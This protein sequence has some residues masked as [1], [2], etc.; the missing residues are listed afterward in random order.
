MPDK[1]HDWEFGIR[2]EG[3]VGDSTE[4]SVVL[5]ENGFNYE[6]SGENWGELPEGWVYKEA[7]A[8][9]VDSKDRVY[10]FNRGT[11]PVIVFDTDGKI[12]DTWGE[13][14]FKNPHGIT[15][16]PDDELFCVDNGDSTVRKFSS[17]GKLLMTIGEPGAGS[18][19]MSG[20]PFAKPTHVAVNKSNG[21][22]Y[23]ADGY[24]NASV[25][26]YSPDGKLLLTWGES[27]TGPG[28]FNIV[29]NVVVDSDGWVYIADRENHRIQA[30]S[31]THLTLPTKA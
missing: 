9:D 18:P 13:G 21:E 14:V 6:L 26:K 2:E 15:V 4:G 16:G 12:I 23:V 5:G 31:Y 22:F 10:V 25:H 28:Q 24:S 30:V 3:H 27:G 29:H 19:K 7:T 11:C 8:V 1:E 20:I 17:E